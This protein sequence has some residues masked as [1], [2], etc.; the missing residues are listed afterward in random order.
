[1]LNIAIWLFEIT[2]KWAWY[3]LFPP[4][5]DIEQTFTEL[6]K[7]KDEQQKID[8]LSNDAAVKQLRSEYQRD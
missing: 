2:L 6:N 8:N 4:K 7:V 3:K 1:M 5:S